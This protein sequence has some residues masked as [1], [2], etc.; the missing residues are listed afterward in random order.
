MIVNAETFRNELKKMLIEAKD[1]GEKYIDVK[2]GDLHR[3]VGD[4]PGKNHKMPSCCSV[5][6]SAMKTNDE[7]LES[8]PSGKGASLVI[9][10]YI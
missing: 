10:Y 1:Q 5:M 9:R 4:Y 3:Q 8:P 6:K 7:I 2:S